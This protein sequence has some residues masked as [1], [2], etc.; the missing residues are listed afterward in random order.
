MVLSTS[1]HLDSGLLVYNFC[2]RG[3]SVEETVYLVILNREL[4]TVNFMCSQQTLRPV[5]FG[6]HVDAVGR[7]GH[8]TVRVAIPKAI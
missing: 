8:G 2:D 4:I 6:D 3:L 1:R 7:D 5:L